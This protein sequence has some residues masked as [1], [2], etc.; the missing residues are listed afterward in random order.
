MKRKNRITLS[1]LSLVM[2]IGTTIAMFTDTTQGK[3]AGEPGAFCLTELSNDY[4]FE[5]IA[6]GEP[7]KI[8]ATLQNKGNVRVKTRVSTAI[9]EYDAESDTWLAND[10]LGVLNSE[11]N[12]S[13]LDPSEV[14][15]VHSIFTMNKNLSNNYQ[16]ELFRITITIEALQIDG[17]WDSVNITSYEFIDGKSTLISS[18]EIPE[19]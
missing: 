1:V 7:R 16:G 6:P 15:E 4:D 9:E 3:L 12:L 13:E 19:V 18:C 2:L 10:N 11:F 8:I 17:D 14:L 5:K